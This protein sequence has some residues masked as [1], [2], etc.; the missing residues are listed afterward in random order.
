MD[1][2]LSAEAATSKDPALTPVR[3]SISRLSDVE[4]EQMNH[5]DLL[6]VVTFSG[7][8]DL[9][10]RKRRQLRVSDRVELELLVNFSRQFC[11]SIV[12]THH[13]KWGWPAPFPGQE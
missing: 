4:I 1:A 13:E 5:D 9:S 8:L 12:N 11:R 7:L 6:D 10:P 2:P 3:V